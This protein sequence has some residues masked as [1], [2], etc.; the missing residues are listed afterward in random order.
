MKKNIFSILILTLVTALFSVLLA[1]IFTACAEGPSGKEYE[2][3]NLPDYKI[4]SD[5]KYV[6][7]YLD[8]KNAPISV[9]ASKNTT[10]ARGTARNTARNTARAMTPDTA[11]RGFDYFEVFFYYKGTVARAAWELGKRASVMDV[12]RTTSGIDYSLTSIYNTAG[13]VAGSAPAGQGSIGVPVEVSPTNAA[14]ILFAGRK[15]DKTLIA[16]GKLVSVDT[17]EPADGDF[18]R[19]TVVKNSTVFVTFELSPF[20]ANTS[21]DITKSSFL[22]DNTGK[23]SPAAGN[24]NVISAL[25]GERYFPL[26]IMPGGKP[27]IN[28]QYSLGIDGEWSDFNDSIFVMEKGQVDKRQARYPAGGGRYYYAKYPEDQ[29]TVVSMTNNQF[30]WSRNVADPMKLQNPI[31]FVIDTSKTVNTTKQDNGIFSFSFSIPVYPLSSDIPKD[32]EDC[33]YIRPAYTSYYYNIDNGVTTGEYNDKNIGGAILCAVDLQKA[34]YE[35]PV[36]RR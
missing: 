30:T 23:G 28:A 12:Y 24:T 25:I 9:N 15:S 10:G 33:W 27:S 29:T 19:D 13:G 32:Q 22:T 18:F 2:D 17:E 35:I 20:T 21:A 16:V 7:I 14:S 31:S 1:A 4:S 34:N 36:E 3:D 8:G 5:W 11:R 26:Y 6:S